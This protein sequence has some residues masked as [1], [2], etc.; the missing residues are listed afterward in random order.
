MDYRVVYADTLRV[1]D[2]FVADDEGVVY[3]I[4]D[5]FA[6]DMTYAYGDTAPRRFLV[7]KENSGD[8]GEIDLPDHQIVKLVG[9][10][11]FDLEKP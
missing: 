8:V 7:V 9:Q 5:I 6:G 3:H 10:R 4:H 2:L 1:G 11:Y